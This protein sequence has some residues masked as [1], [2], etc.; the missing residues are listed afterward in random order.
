M[1]HKILIVDDE[2]DIVN[3]LSA[4]LRTEAFQVITAH[5]GYHGTKAALEQN[6]DL[7]VLDIGMPAGNGHEVVRCLRQRETTK[8][9]PII[10]LTAHTSPRDYALAAEGGVDRYITKPYRP[11]KLVNVINELLSD[12]EAK[13]LNEADES[14]GRK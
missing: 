8:D 14:R 5:D 4:R 1:K 7:I 9:T 6:P 13:E 3:C 11:D 12:S 10:F 2:P